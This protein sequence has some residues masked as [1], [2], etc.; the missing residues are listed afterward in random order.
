MM[1]IAGTPSSLTQM[2]LVESNISVATLF[3]PDIQCYTSLIKKCL[4]NLQSSHMM[5]LCLL[6]R[7]QLMI[8]HNR[9]PQTRACILFRLNTYLLFRGT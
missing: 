2:F 3:L 1:L 7:Y 6:V 8:F 5:L 9:T 4:Y